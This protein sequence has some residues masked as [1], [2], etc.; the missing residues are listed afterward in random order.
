MHQWGAGVFP[1]EPGLRPPAAGTLGRNELRRWPRRPLPRPPRPHGRITLRLQRRS[2]PRTTVTSPSTRHSRCISQVSSAPKRFRTSGRHP[3]PSMSAQRTATSPIRRTEACCSTPTARPP[4]PWTTCLPYTVPAS[5]TLPQR[6][7][8]SAPP[9]IV[10]GDDA[11]PVMDEH[12]QAVSDFLADYARQVIDPDADGWLSNVGFYQMT[13]G[14]G[15]HHVRRP[16]PVPQ[17]R[18]R[19]ARRLAGIVRHPTTDPVLPHRRSGA[20]IPGSRTASCARLGPRC[21]PSAVAT[22]DSAT[23][24]CHRSLP[25]DA[26]C[27]LPSCTPTRNLAP[28]TWRAPKS[29]STDRVG[30]SRHNPLD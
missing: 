5:P 26:T 13:G 18:P 15:D 12:L 4:T 20:A 22:S 8:T 6:S 23:S 19:R 9:P 27:H 10:I 1:H 29:T 3:T 7:G 28:T 30:R 25:T 16:V 24:A 21:H 14:R 11:T 17:S 2:T